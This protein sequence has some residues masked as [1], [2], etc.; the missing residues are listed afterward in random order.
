MS[1]FFF[2]TFLSNNHSLNHIPIPYRSLFLTL[3]SEECGPGPTIKKH[4]LFGEIT[5]I[6]K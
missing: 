4:V 6:V 3:K 2:I 5:V 1:F